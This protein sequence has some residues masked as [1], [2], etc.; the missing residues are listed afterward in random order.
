MCTLHKYKYVQVCLAWTKSGLQARIWL[1]SRRGDGKVER[2]ETL[3]FQ[4]VPRMT[5][6]PY[7]LIS[8]YGSM[9]VWEY[10]SMGVTSTESKYFY[11]HE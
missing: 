5:Q 7:R 11:A 3:T 8:G 6:V 2:M 10:G 4:Q 9:G 1:S